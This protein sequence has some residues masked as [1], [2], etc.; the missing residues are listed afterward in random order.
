MNI[1]YSEKPVKRMAT[2]YFIGILLLVHQKS[3]YCEPSSTTVTSDIR[4]T[5]DTEYSLRLTFG[6]YGMVVIKRRDT[7]WSVC[8]NHFN[9]V[10]AGVICREMGY[11]GGFAYLLIRKFDN[12]LRPLIFS[13]G[14]TGTEKTIH[15]CSNVFGGNISDCDASS[16]AAVHCYNNSGYEFRLVNE[17]T[18][19]YGLLE[20]AIDGEWRLFC[21]YEGFDYNSRAIDYICET[22]GYS[23]GSFVSRSQRDPVEKVWITHLSYC[24]GYASI[25]LRC[26]IVLY[27]NEEPFDARRSPNNRYRGIY[28]YYCRTGLLPTIKCF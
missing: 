5:S 24:D 13:F 4:P 16:Y 19:G 7:L 28:S 6:R 9:D 20:M 15:D 14:C 25:L 22:L 10:D 3:V 12:G 21:G 27:S 2:F 8:P 1:F 18:P 23:A 26:P 11:K 17:S